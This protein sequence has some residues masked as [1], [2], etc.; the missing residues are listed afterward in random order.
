MSMP[1]GIFE[2]GHAPHAHEEDHLLLR[3]VVMAGIG[4]IVV[5]IVT[6]VAMFGLYHVL[7]RQE[8]RMSPPANPLAAAEGPRVPPQPRLQAH[9]LKD[10]EELRKAET[11]RLT[12]YGWV[13]KRAG[14]VHIPIDR[15][16]D[17]LAARAGGTGAAAQ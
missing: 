5:L 11:E 4:L 3:P 14:T 6:A 8:A 9:P 16:M 15:A 7:A 13:D 2:H 17:L 1:Q 12:T 10:L